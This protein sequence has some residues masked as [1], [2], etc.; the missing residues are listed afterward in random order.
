MP[1]PIYDSVRST[2]N[3]VLSTPNSNALT[4]PTGWKCVSSGDGERVMP[5]TP[6]RCTLPKRS[7]DSLSAGTALRATRTP[8][9]STSNARVPPGLVL[10]ICCMSGKLSTGRPLIVSTRSPGWKPATWAALPGCTASTRGDVLGLPKTMK[11]AAKMAMANRKFATGP[12]TTIAARDPTGGWTK[13]CRRSSSL[14]AA[15]AAWSGTLAAL[16][17]PKNFTYPPSGI[18]ESCHRVPRRSLKPKSSGPNPMEK[19]KTLTPHQRAIRKCPSSWK[20]TTRVRTNRKGIRYP[21]TPP[22]SALIPD[23]K[24][25]FMRPQSPP[26]PESPSEP[27]RLRRLCGNFGQEPACQQ[28]CIMV[29]KEC[30]LNASRLGPVSRHCRLEGAL[31]ERG[32]PGKAQPVGEEFGDRHLVSGVEDSGGGAPRL[33]GA[34]GETQRRKPGEIRLLEGQRCRACQIEP[35]GRARDP[36]GPSKAIRDR[37]AHVG[38]AQLRD[39][40]AIAEFDQA[41]HDRLRM[42]QDVDL[43]R[44]QR[45]K[46]IGF[47]QLEPFVH[48]RGRVDRHLRAHRP[49]GMLEGLLDR[50]R[51]DGLRARGSERTSGGSE[52]GAA[53]VLASAAAHSLEE[54]IVLGID[55][56]HG[57]P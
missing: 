18:A 46:M 31:D 44:S 23:R 15:S 3:H 30:F 53:H 16:S 22:P 29:N 40:R 2:T 19:T 1:P 51:S 38:A 27:V 5:S 43:L 4:G 8:P 25:K 33:E 21:S 36:L 41:V 17:S 20:N 32:Y 24:S 7:L 52:N 12:A 47:D 45:K 39:E 35:R 37:D 49:V 28:S 10:T 42:D 55:R 6:M 34:A 9:R 14:I 48:Q 57:G 11:R 26:S 56:Q 50:C 13:L 54:G